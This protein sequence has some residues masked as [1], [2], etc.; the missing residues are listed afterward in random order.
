MDHGSPITSVKKILI[1]IIKPYDIILFK[2]SRNMQME[3]IINMIDFK[4]I[5]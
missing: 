3:K 4:S 1:D 5:K 2:G